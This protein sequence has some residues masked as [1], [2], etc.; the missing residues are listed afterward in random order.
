M[1]QIL[2]KSFAITTVTFLFGSLISWALMPLH[3]GERM[4]TQITVMSLFSI[5]RAGR[6]FWRKLFGKNANRASALPTAFIASNRPLLP[7]HVWNGEASGQKS[8]NLC[9][10]SF[11]NIHLGYQEIMLINKNNVNQ[12]KLLAEWSGT[13]SSGQI[14]AVSMPSVLQWA[15]DLI[16]Y[17]ISR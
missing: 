13:G 12:L 14:R 2:F 5:W 1:G 7:F 11:G 16:A 4:L 10:W 8:P 6:S 9:R 15:P 17:I 3:F